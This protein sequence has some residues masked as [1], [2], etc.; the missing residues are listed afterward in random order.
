MF[1]KGRSGNPGGRPKLEGEVRELA[2]KHSKRAIL[3]L[4]EL[5]ESDNEKV[6][7]LAANSVLDRAFGKPAQSLSVG[8]ENGGPVQAVLQIIA[9]SK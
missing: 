4:V 9:K 8:G 3:R 7:A 1:T 6:A 5:M 2:Q